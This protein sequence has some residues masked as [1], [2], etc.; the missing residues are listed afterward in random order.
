MILNDLTSCLEEFADLSLQESYDN[1]GLLVGSPDMDIKK[2]LAC[3]DVTIDVVKEA[4][5]NQCNLIISHHPIIFHKIKNIR[6]DN[7]TGQIIFEAIKNNIALYAAHTNMDNVSTGLNAILCR[8]LTILDYSVL[9]PSQNVLK[10][11]VTFCPK[12]HAE[13]V[14]NALFMAGAGHI[15][16]YDCC[17]YSANGVGSF[18]ALK[19]AHPFVGKM[20]KIH[21]E[22]E[23]RIELIFPSFIEKKLVQALLEV[24]PY[25]EVAYDIYSLSN[26]YMRSGSGMI[27]KLE[28][29]MKQSQFLDHIKKVLKVPFLKHSASCV[30]NI[31]T[32][33]VCG[34]SGS[35]LI[36]EAIKN[37]ADAFITADVKYHDFFDASQ[38]LLVV[39]A[40]HFETEQFIKE[41]F[42]E[43]LIKKFPKFAVLISKVQTN[44]VNYY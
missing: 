13:K 25:E 35:F 17:S 26:S 28:K 27:G 12:I 24:H 10:K 37:K 6:S 31:H 11:L 22:K 19:G 21:L 18:R 5:K 14:K 44:P 8:K 4:I 7:P 23:A 40:G 34:G 43:I 38:K 42:V 20:N 41:L 2:A 29:P 39:D 1:S 32:V 36:N 30:K 15:G 16:N 3:L 33:A 9:Q